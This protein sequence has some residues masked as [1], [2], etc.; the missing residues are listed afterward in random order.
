MEQKNLR[1]GELYSEHNQTTFMTNGNGVA[2]FY[3]SIGH[4]KVQVE[5]DGQIVEDE[6]YKPSII[7]GITVYLNGT[8]KGT[9]N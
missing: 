8:N 5:K 7:K 3:T 6:F 2:R 1:K 4:Y 9:L